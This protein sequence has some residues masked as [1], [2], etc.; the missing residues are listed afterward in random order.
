MSPVAVITARDADWTAAA[1][2][3]SIAGVCRAGMQYPG[4]GRENVGCLKKGFESA[5]GK[6]PRRGRY[7]PSRKRRESPVSMGCECRSALMGISIG[8]GEDEYGVFVGNGSEV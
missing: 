4:R 8:D 6:V 3:G 1:L 7:W 5:V 2:R